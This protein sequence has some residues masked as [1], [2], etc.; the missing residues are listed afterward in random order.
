MAN[1][2]FFLDTVGKARFLKTGESFHTASQAILLVFSAPEG[3]GSRPVSIEEL[4]L[5][6]DGVQVGAE[7]TGAI[8]MWFREGEGTLERRGLGWRVRISVTMEALYRAMQLRVEAE[9]I[10]SDLLETPREIFSGALELEIFDQPDGLGLSAIEFNLRMSKSVLGLF[11]E[12]SFEGGDLRLPIKRMSSEMMWRSELVMPRKLKIQPVGFRVDDSDSDPTGDSWGRLTPHAS[13]LWGSELLELEFRPIRYVDRGDLKE[14]TR[15]QKIMNS[16]EDRKDCRVIEVFLVRSR[17]PNGGGST[18]DG[19]TGLDNVVVSDLSMRN[20]LLLA[21]E[22]GHVLSGLHPRQMNN[23]RRLWVADERTVLEPSLRLDR[24]NPDF[25]T[26]N[27]R[28][29]ATNLAI[30]GAGC[31][32]R[33]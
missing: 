23:R 18:R 14:S 32:R 2:I 25:N 27:N 24:A 7:D 4:H 30:D 20:N 3:V 19:G 13:R 15:I 31:P 9:E 29:R 33:R 11:D 28:R 1:E 6:G 21:H 12:V 16:W 10:D 5:L 17:V 22:L 26:D 8:S